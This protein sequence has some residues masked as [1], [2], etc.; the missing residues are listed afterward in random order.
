MADN[1]LLDNGS[2]PDFTA[3]SDDVGGVQYP[4]V[5]LV[6]GTL[7]SSTVIGGDDI[8][9]LDVDVTRV[10]PGTGATHLGKAED[11]AHAN[12]DTGVAVWAVRSDTPSSTAASNGDYTALTTDSS[13]RLHVAVG[14]MPGASTITDTIGAAAMTNVV[15]DD[16]TPL[17][18]K[19]TSIAIANSQTD[20]TLVAAV[21]SKKIR[22]LSLFSQCQGTGT[23][24]TL[25]SDGAPDVRI[26]SYFPA[27]N[28]GHVLPFNPI[29]WFETTSGAALLATTGAG[30]TTD[31]TLTYVEV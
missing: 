23:Q 13:G 11:S 27:D 28:G 5:K 10:V 8:N 31:F 21:A 26:H 6:D 18:P 4:Y 3:A 17:T 25:E 7:N 12:G 22:V 1:V 20:S 19:F 15:M 30:S 2:N 16:V 24:V 9:G 14:T 29:G